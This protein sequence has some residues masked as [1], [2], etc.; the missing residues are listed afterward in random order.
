M[1]ARPLIESRAR[2]SR[3]NSRALTAIIDRRSADDLPCIRIPIYVRPVHR[4]AGREPV[5]SF[6][7]G[8]LRAVYVSVSVCCLGEVIEFFERRREN[9]RLLE[10]FRFVFIPN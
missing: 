1:S 6:R 5:D 8:R 10:C 4:I 2:N 3:S 9:A 7:C